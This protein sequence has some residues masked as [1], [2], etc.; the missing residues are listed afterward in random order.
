MNSLENGTS[1][2]PHGLTLYDAVEDHIFG[3]TM[4]EEYEDGNLYLAYEV[5]E[6]IDSLKSELAILKEKIEKLP[7]DGS[8]K[9]P[10]KEK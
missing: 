9:Q 10:T 2:T 3:G 7:S 1:R 4:L 8:T 5:D 6:M